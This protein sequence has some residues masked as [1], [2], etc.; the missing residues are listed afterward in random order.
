MKRKQKTYNSFVTC[1]IKANGYT[2][3][4]ITETG[5]VYIRYSVIVTSPTGKVTVC[6]REH[7]KKYRRFASGPHIARMLKALYAAVQCMTQ[8]PFV[9]QGKSPISA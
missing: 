1:K 6:H 7:F 8:E 3:R 5:R 2:A 4:A 9:W